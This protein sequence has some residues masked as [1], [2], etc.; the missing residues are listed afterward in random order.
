MKRSLFMFYAILVLVIISFSAQ[1]FIDFSVLNIS[2][3]CIVLASSLITLIYLRWS[4]AY[5]NYPLSS[6]AIF[7]LLVTTQLGALVAQFLLWASLTHD[8]RA[9]VETF[10]YLFMFQISAIIAHF[11]Y[12]MLANNKTKKPSILRYAFEKLGL[13]KTPPII[14]IWVMGLIGLLSS[15]LARGDSGS[16]VAN[17]VQFIMWAPFL[18]P[19]YRAR[20][21][22]LYCSAKL[23]YIL[24]AL[25]TL[26]ILAMG[27]VFNARGFM[28]NGIVTLGSV[29]FL[30]TLRSQEKF[31]SADFFKMFLGALFIITASPPLSDLSTSMAVARADRD[32]IS[33][34]KLAQNTFEIL[35]NKRELIDQYRHK[36]KAETH[37]SSYDEYYIANPLLARFA[38]TKFH[39]NM[40]YFGSKLNDAQ[41]DDLAKYSYTAIA[42]ILPDPLLK[43]KWLDVNLD[44]NQYQYSMGDYISVL[45]IGGQ[46]GGYRTGSAFGQ[47]F[48]LFGYF[49][50]FIFMGLCVVLF[51]IK[52]LFTFKNAEGM[53]YIAPIGLFGLYS[54]FLNAI[55]HESIHEYVYDI[56]RWFP[57]SVILYL[58]VFQFAC[59]VSYIFTSISQF[60]SKNIR[61]KFVFKI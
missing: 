56:F 47:G 23:N 30:A 61:N 13:Y 44:K 34:V 4:E 27:I 8:L 19:I 24:L 49:Y 18:I 7:G 28:L 43:I 53:V 45:A 14:A 54:L 55:N 11:F 20:L 15:I 59:L 10:I 46:L 29:L 6:F 42:L 50:V 22:E 41:L 16:K 33:G 1:F 25:Y 32:K 58:L 38:M 51:Y 57:Q 12:R 52:D 60:N 31:T 5:I 2:A 40:F 3:A 17:G 26:G 48:T 9:P 37:N 39:D 21:G 36:E 35:T